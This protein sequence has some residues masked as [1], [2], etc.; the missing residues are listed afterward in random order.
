MAKKLLWWFF[1]VGFVVTFPTVLFAATF[2][3]VPENTEYYGA[4]EYMVGKG[5]IQGYPDGSFKPDKPINRAE[6]LKVLLLAYTSLKGELEVE[7]NAGQW[8]YEY[9]LTGYNLGI[10]EGYPDGTFKPGD[11]INIAESIKLVFLQF[12]VS[13]SENLESDPYPDVKKDIWYALYADY[14][15]RKNLIEP[16]D[17]GNLDAGR[18]MTLFPVKH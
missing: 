2:P 10:V 5:V 12:D 3:D 8:F 11:T 15:K 6:A 4:V 1:T 16:L 9:V 13:L 14:S 7:V 17:N 18:K